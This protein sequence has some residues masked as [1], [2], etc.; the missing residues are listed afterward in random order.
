MMVGGLRAESRRKATR[1]CADHR[2]RHGRGEGGTTLDGSTAREH[3]L[4]ALTGCLP[5]KAPLNEQ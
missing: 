4:Q 3:G 2:G 1:A 5:A